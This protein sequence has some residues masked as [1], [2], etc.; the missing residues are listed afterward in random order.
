MHDLND[1]ISSLISI[2]KGKSK[3]SIKLQ[4]SSCTEITQTINFSERVTVTE[5]FNREDLS[6]GE[7]RSL[8]YASE[9]IDSIMDEIQWTVEMMEDEEDQRRFVQ[10]D[11][12][13]FSA[14]G[15][16]S[17][18]DIEARNESTKFVKTLVLQQMTV[19]KSQGIC[20]DDMVARVYHDCAV[21]HV[22][23]ANESARLHAE[24]VMRYL[25][26]TR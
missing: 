25:Q 3:K 22:Q 23:K 19:F 15:L 20:N 8:W 6:E 7:S 11:D 21:P 17:Q 26:G 16:S 13:C 14:Q 5:I 18:K 2:D 4:G 9:E 10:D 1:S 24:D 12:V